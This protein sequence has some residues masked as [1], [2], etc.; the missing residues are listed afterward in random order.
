MIIFV[1]DNPERAEG[2]LT[3]LKQKGYLYSVVSDEKKALDAIRT[4]RANLILIDTGCASFHGFTLCKTIKEDEAQKD[5]P[6]LLLTDLCDVS[7]LL[8]VL[9]SRAD[10][11]IPKPA[12][13]EALLSAIDDLV[14]A[15]E[16]EK[17]QPSVRTRFVVSHEGC[18]YSVYADRRQLLEF[19][20]STFEIAVRIRHEQE[21]MQDE[22]QG[23]IK[24]LS[25]RLLAVTGERD[26][27][28]KNLHMEVEERTKTINR[29]NAALQAKDQQETLL[30]TQSDKFL[31]D[32]AEKGTALESTRRLLEEESRMAAALKEQVAALN[33]ERESIQQEQKERL[34]DLAV[35]VERLN[36][37][38]SSKSTAL[39]QEQLARKGLEEQL[40]LTG[41]ALKQ[42]QEKNR[43]ISEELAS[44]ASAREA[45]ALGR[46][47]LEEDAQNL[48]RELDAREKESHDR[49]S[50]VSQSLADMQSAL[51]QAQDRLSD[52]TVANRE[53]RE[54][55]AILTCERD[56]LA[57][58]HEVFSDS[59]G[60]AQ[61]DLEA[62]FHTLEQEQ[63]LLT[64]A[65]TEREELR[66][67][68]ANVQQFLDSA[69]RDIGLLTA[70]LSE[71]KEKHKSA[72]DRLN[73]AVREMEEKDR[74]I[75]A[76]TKGRTT[77]TGEPGGQKTQSAGVI[78][79][80]PAPSPRQEQAGDQTRKPDDDIPGPSHDP[81]G[82]QEQEPLL[83]SPSVK[84]QL[85]EPSP[86]AMLPETP[87]PA[88]EGVGAEPQ[89][90]PSVPDERGAEP[91]TAETI[92]TPPPLRQPADW[93]M[94]RNLWF[95]MIKW[96][97]HTDKVPEDKRK[98]LLSDLMKMS[99]LVQQGR[100]LTNRQE[101]EIRT[102][103]AKM[104]ALGYLF[105]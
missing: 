5:L 1:S 67:K 69:S 96:V 35:N 7:V 75:H 94:N 25:E 79:L 56:R 89:K 47:K 63:C 49:I 41:G 2:L 57:Q 4:D 24:E 12:D 52:E 16:A 9:D 39:A 84:L 59:Q 74:V 88:P 62:Q 83:P 32:L 55:V 64:A 65:E 38:I 31:Q 76:L 19:L 10:A 13:P 29:L 91:K 61:A 18:D 53:L 15:H 34:E 78:E 28:V 33:K 60:K 100:H 54:Q 101:T 11:F 20:L 14:K 17:P 27:T 102:L 40:V 73:A 86:P 68:Y 72:E 87:A 70:A 36:S 6:V 104:K 46:V 48:R 66:A 23:A 30:R 90:S 97:H 21:R 51:I 26:A 99:R 8:A 95:D 77:L 43:A 22:L 45:E 103:L 92:P 81:A 44:A 50:H 93:S 80:P 3:H 58:S 98:S 105:P 85:P 82:Q 37:E 71:E 42:E